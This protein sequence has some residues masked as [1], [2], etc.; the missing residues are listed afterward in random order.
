VRDRDDT[1]LEKP[2]GD[3]AAFGLIEPAVLALN[4]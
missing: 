4:A 2:D 3:V 1:T